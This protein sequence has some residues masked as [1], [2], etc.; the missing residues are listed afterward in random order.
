MLEGIVTLYGESALENAQGYLPYIGI[1]LGYAT[2]CAVFFARNR[3][4]KGHS[5][6]ETDRKFTTYIW[7]LPGFAVA[8]IMVF[9]QSEIRH[10]LDRIQKTQEQEFKNTAPAVQVKLGNSTKN[11]ATLLEVRANNMVPF[12]ARWGV[13]AKGQERNKNEL[14]SGFMTSWEEFVPTEQVKRWLFPVS[15]NRNRLHSGQIQLV[16]RYESAYYRELNRPEHLKGKIL[17]R[18]GY[19]DEGV[20]LPRELPSD[21][22]DAR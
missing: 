13:S 18:Y 10:E 20:K 6:N 17:Q 4:R 22:T 16:F 9:G 8:A 11:A 12:R 1:L 7:L 2:A 15:I 5:E 3:R 21:R 19:D 14:L